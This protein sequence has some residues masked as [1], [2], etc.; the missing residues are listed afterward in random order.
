MIKQNSMY[1]NRYLQSKIDKAIAFIQHGEK[2]ALSMN[3]DGYFVAF[4]GGKDSQVLLW[5]VQQAGVKYRAY[6]SVTT[7]DPP[8][9]VRF[10][11]DNYPEVVFLHPRENF[12]KLVAKR[13][14][15]T[16]NRR[17]CCSILK[18]TAGVGYVT[19]IGVRRDESSKRK[20]YKE[21]DV[22]SRRKEHQDSERVYNIDEILQAE[23]QC[24]KGKD[25][26][27]LRPI[28][29]F[30]DS[31]I[32]EVIYTNNLPVNPCYNDTKRVGCIFCPFS[33]KKQI[34]DYCN[35]YPKA[36]AKIIDSI[37][38]YQSKMKQKAELPPDEYF[39]WW[40]SKKTLK[41][42]KAEKRQ[43]KIELND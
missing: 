1:K 31:E 29:D 5:L 28:L 42:Y 35:K 17:F 2:L 11:R 8:Q 18:E 22:V 24:I 23:H 40:L 16:M 34:L 20:N 7:N 14:L 26:L 27:V 37:T 36:K 9:N 25:K 4:S 43:T 12:Y 3:A 41:Q 32:W 38:Q 10:I 30:T 33:S 6:Y 15:P 19:L 39:D 13:G 21:V